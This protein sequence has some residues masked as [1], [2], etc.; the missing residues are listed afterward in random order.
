MKTE[1]FTSKSCCGATSVILKIDCSISSSLIDYLKSIGFKEEEHFTKVGIL[2][3]TNSEF[4]L[5]G[6]IGSNK[7][8]IK[9]R[10]KDCNQKLND[11]EL[12]LQKY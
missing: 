2:Y 9:C 3:V 1:R 11:V 5:T 8:Q 6:P 10:K 12:L 4:I 7:L